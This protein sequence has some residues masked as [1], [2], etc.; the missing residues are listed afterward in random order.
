M[1]GLEFDLTETGRGPALLLLPGSYATPAAWKGV[2]AALTARFRILSTSLPGYGST[3]DVRPDTD[4]D[5]G[6]MV[7]FVG[8]VVEAVGE[9]VHVVG[10][11]WGAHLLLAAL[12]AR[13]IE[14]LS[15]VCFEANPLFARRSDGPFPWRPDI[16]DMVDR[17]E[18]ALASGDPD[19]AAIIIDFYSRPGTFLGMPEHVRDFCRATARTN[20]R[21]W[22]SA[23]RF[24]PPFDAF[25]AVD[26]PVTL[27]RGGET[28]TP[29]IDV[30]EQ[31]A[32]HIPNARKTVI[33]AADHFLIS[34]HPA[35][36]AELLEAHLHRVAA[37]T[38]GDRGMRDAA[39]GA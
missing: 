6:W 22:H 35:A 5:I 27:V 24:T 8:Q 34:T 10:H 37:Q 18:N 38:G 14:P 36:C 29:M 28:P 2:Q 12:L 16:E 21:D 23:A 39:A 4:P 25:A 3:P 1:T 30:T 19:A 9:P 32:A 33:P 26:V 13:R 31:L 17:F 7:E 20:L 15:V 11:S